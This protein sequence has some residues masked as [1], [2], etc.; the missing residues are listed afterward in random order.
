MLVG[1][2]Q[3]GDSAGP[4]DDNRSPVQSAGSDLLS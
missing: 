3:F 4:M 2:H 1:K